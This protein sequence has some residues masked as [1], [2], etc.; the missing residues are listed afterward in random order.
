MAR[1]VFYSFHYKPDNWRAA[2]VRNM[3]VIEGNE[4]C[5]DNDWESVTKGGDA[6]IEKW[7][8][9]QL[10]G[11]TC[12]LVLVG[13]G[14]AGRKWITHEIQE[15]WNG[16]L[17]VVG[18]RIHNLK[19]VNGQRTFPGGN[20]FDHLHFVNK[21]S[22]LLSSVAQLYDPPYTLSTDVY[23]YIYENLEAWIEEAIEIH[24]NCVI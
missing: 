24:D 12:A 21:P 22:K 4:P 5:S 13:S 16:G 18:V 17:G 8:A 20:P 2:Q 14:T 11:R 19:D 7:I 23:A 15:A 3:G 10:N 9:K 1:N 6:A